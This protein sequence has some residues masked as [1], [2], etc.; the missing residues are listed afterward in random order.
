MDSNATLSLSPGDILM[1]EG[2][3]S[4]RIF[5]VHSGTFNVLVRKSDGRSTKVGE[6]KEGELVG[7]MAF[8]DKKPRS[9]TVIAA[10]PAEVMVVSQ[11]A[12]QK[13]IDQQPQWFKKFINTLINRL[14]G[15]NKE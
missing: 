14:R 9:A 8:I 10:T 15:K 13:I 5:L 1:N 11:D 2:D 7:E 4:D 12:F 6:V 3:K